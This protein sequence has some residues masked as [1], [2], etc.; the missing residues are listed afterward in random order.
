MA[1][2]YKREG[3]TYQLPGVNDLHGNPVTTDKALFYNLVNDMIDT[4][5]AFF[6]MVGM[7]GATLD[8]STAVILQP[9]VNLD[10]LINDE[11]WRVYIRVGGTGLMPDPVGSGTVTVNNTG[12]FIGVS[13]PAN[14]ASISTV[15]T[16]AFRE[17]PIVPDRFYTLTTSQSI[18][19]GLTSA[20]PRISA[21]APMAYHLTMT[22]R[23]FVV[24]IWNQA[25]TEDFFQT[26]AFCVQ[27][28]V[29]CDGTVSVGGAKPLYVITNILPVA[30]TNNN[31]YPNAGPKN[32]WYYTIIRQ[33]D[34]DT[35]E[36][37]FT[38]Y[39]D[40]YIGAVPSGERLFDSTLS[41]S[42]EQFGAAI[43]YFPTRWYT[44]VQAD[45]GE[46]LLIFPFGIGSSR[47]VH[48][49]EIDL[50]AVSKADA[51]NSG[52]EAPINVYGE[53]RTYTAY[54]SNNDRIAN[55]GGVRMFIL[56]NGPE[57]V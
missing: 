57:F 39:S 50:I 23:G 43:N 11:P 1:K 8:Q 32:E 48:N 47:F 29:T 52:Q 56:T 35:P 42:R 22:T 9:T 55:N 46:F 24:S 28:G 54:T 3:L 21:T 37:N 38:K 16:S 26:G 7:N 10:P 41:D 15:N 40:A 34:T 25:I 6:T 45:T 33:T 2:T 4:S 31:S 14:L 53:E 19:V 13:T 44:P 51:Y 27:R 20:A 18:V 12:L 36:P 49:D 5:G 17:F 30:S